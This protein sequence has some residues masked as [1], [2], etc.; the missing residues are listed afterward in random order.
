MTIKLQRSPRI[1]IVRL[2]RHPERRAA[3]ECVERLRGY[4][5]QLLHQRG[6]NKEA[7]NS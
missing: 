3:P 7:G 2:I 6:A 4:I 5:E 1:S